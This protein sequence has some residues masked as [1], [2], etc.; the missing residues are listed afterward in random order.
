MRDFFIFIFVIFG[1]LLVKTLRY[2]IVG[3]E[4]FLDVKKKGGRVI[5]AIWHGQLALFFPIAYHTKV[6]GI[7]SK[8]KDGEIA[9]KVIKK[10]GFDS[11]RG[12][13][14]RSG[15]TA[16][17][18]AE[19][20]LEKNY[21]IMITV[22]G[23]RGPKFD[24]KSGAVYIAKRF[25]CTI[26]PAVAKVNRYKSFSS[27][28]NF[29]FPFP[30]AKVDIFLGDPIVFDSSVKREDIK[31]DTEKLKMKMNEMTKEYAEFYL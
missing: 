16:I 8:S 9:A 15:A 6:C 31:N 4:R 26:I 1:K 17:I 18:D 23:P 24:V 12:S 25:G 27:W 14:S 7:V 19:K 22:D 2:R 20:Y 13:S 30:F 3:I 28:D 5:F 11:I 21:D 29:L 10:F